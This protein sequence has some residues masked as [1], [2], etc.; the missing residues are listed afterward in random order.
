[1][2]PGFVWLVLTIASVQASAQEPQPQPAGT[3][4]L[5][6]PLTIEQAVQLARDNYPALQ[7]QRARA[8]AAAEGPAVAHTA[9]L[10]R[11]DAVWQ[12]NRAT[13]NNVFGLLL[14]QSIIPPVSGPV[15]PRTSDSVWG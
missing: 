8:A 11:I 9:Y 1:M 2:K 5:P 12:G 14:P 15:L 13:H 4:S 3:R 6:S 7:E 10:P